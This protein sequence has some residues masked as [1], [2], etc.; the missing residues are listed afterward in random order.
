MTNGVAL[1]LVLLAVAALALDL[2]VLQQ[3][4]AVQLARSFLQLVEWVSFW[5]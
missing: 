1:V 4:L 5:R 2:W 3:G